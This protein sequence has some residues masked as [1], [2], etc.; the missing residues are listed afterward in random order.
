MKSNFLQGNVILHDVKYGKGNEILN[1]NKTRTDIRNPQIKKIQKGDH[2]KV[3][4]RIP[5]KFSLKFQAKLINVNS[6]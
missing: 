1:S 2:L 6:P 4:L 5:K 3:G